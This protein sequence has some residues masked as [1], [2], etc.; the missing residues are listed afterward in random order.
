MFSD[1]AWWCIPVISATWGTK[2]TGSLSM[3]YTGKSEALSEK[4]N[5]KGLRVWLKW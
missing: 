5:A 2:V 1:W 4:L 3:P